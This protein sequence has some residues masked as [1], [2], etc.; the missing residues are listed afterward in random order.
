MSTSLT[1]CRRHHATGAVVCLSS[2]KTPYIFYKNCHLEHVTGPVISNVMFVRNHATHSITEKGEQAMPST[3][4]GALASHYRLPVNSPL[5]R[6]L[7]RLSA[8]NTGLLS[9][10]RVMVGDCSTDL[11]SENTEAGNPQECELRTPSEKVSQT[12]VNL[13]SHRYRV[14]KAS[15]DI[16]E[17]HFHSPARRSKGN[18]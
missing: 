17:G 2:A 1:V 5:S 6:H 14:S 10:R 13:R 7:S 15:M 9:K 3:P 11:F 4:I 18:P 12:C 8:S 16:A